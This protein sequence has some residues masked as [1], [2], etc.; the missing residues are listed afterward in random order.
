MRQNWAMYSIRRLPL[1]V[2]L[3]LTS[4]ATLSMPAGA[5]PAEPATGVP[6]VRMVGQMLMIGVP[7]P[8]LDA[9]TASLIQRKR[10]GN[11]VY[12]KRNALSPAQL[13]A[14]SASLQSLAK[15]ATALP[16]FI[17]IDQEGTPTVLRLGDE[18]GFTT[19]RFN[20]EIGCLAK[21]DLPR[22]E[23]LARREAAAIGEE[24]LAAGINLDLA[25]VA[26]VWHN[27]ENVV[28][29]RTQR[30]FGKDP[31]LV[32]ALVAAFIDGL[33]D[34]GTRAVTKHFPGHGNTTDD[35]HFTLPEDP[36]S[37]P[38]LRRWN[39]PPFR[40]AISAHTDVVMSAHVVYPALD[41]RRD[42]QG[43]PIPGTLSRPILTTLL[44][45]RMGF[46]GVVVTDEFSMAGLTNGESNV[47]R[48]A[49]R[50]VEA[51]VDIINVLDQGKAETIYDALLAE[52]RARPEFKARIEQSYQRIVKA[53]K[54][55][56][57]AGNPADV[58]SPAHLALQSELAQL[59]CP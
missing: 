22:A 56:P 58:R 6:L 10:I 4:F 42:A 26:D 8:A 37:I 46:Q 2:L 29:G 59:G 43:R 19:L 31:R 51:G 49:V 45:H 39:F 5:R 27:P 1:G 44:R 9:R 33:H 13:R 28:V 17:A 47:A 32:S 23:S 54:A 24:A 35:S 57:E 18:N 41:S 12:L 7:G 53:K 50:A 34:A 15:S 48:A 30:T 40:A 14:L 55:L 52:A 38:Q 25:P 16:M 21:T 20:P 3:V 36:Q 11:A